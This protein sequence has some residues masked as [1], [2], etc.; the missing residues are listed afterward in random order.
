MIYYAYDTFINFCLK[1][2]EDDSKLKEEKFCL[3]WKED[4]LV[5]VKI[6]IFFE[7]ILL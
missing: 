1:L 2:K 4:I 7:V 6:K 5:E 3:M